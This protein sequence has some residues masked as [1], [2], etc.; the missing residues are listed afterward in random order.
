M[1]ASKDERNRILALVEEGQVSAEEAAKLL[2]TLEMETVRPLTRG[3]E[4]ML[5]VR[6]TNIGA[7]SP[8]MHLAAALPVRLLTTSLQLGVRLFP[9][10]ENHTLEEILRSIEQGATGRLL[11]LQDLEHGERL[12]IFV[13]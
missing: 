7:K 5:R 2:D 13:D 1:A 4:R 8:M 10:L 11:D 3:N 6:A 9:Q 12:E